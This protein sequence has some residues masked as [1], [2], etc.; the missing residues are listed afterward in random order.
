[1]AQVIDYD[2]GISA[3]DSG[4]LRP[5]LD[6]I[7]L[8]V[9]G[10]RAAIIDT[11]VNSSVP[12]VLAA[13]RDK[14]L[15]PEQVD[16]VIL[17]HVHL[18]HAGGAGLLLSKLP[19]ARLTVHP[20][21]TRHLVDPTKLIE[22]TIAVY[23]TEHMRSLYGEIVPVPG[24]RIVE[25]AHESTLALNGREFVF[26]DTPGH[27]RHHVCILDKKSG[28]L[29]AGDTFGLSYREL[30]CNGRQFVI[31]TSS[32]TH[33]DPVAEHQS[34]DLILGLKPG[35]VYVT[36]YSQL[37]DIARMADDMHRL[38]DAY[39]GLARRQQDA[40]ASRH[41]RLKAGMTDIILGEAQRYEW[42]LPREDVLE[43]FDGDIELNA[44]GLAIWLDSERAVK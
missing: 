12:L 20:R 37:R 36:H 22:G 24:D 35:A 15:R 21:G 8:I 39:V 9:E 6:A 10:G 13:L 26:F 44:Q 18:D 4:Y 32:P 41:Q 14:G 3:I 17:T 19:N 11:G 1:M 29:F 16:Y 43:I 5:Q 2:F 23:G 33:F 42:R 7:H 38:V 34:L 28:H 31:P 30:D 25:T 40:G 27:A